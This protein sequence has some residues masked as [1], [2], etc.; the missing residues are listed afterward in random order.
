MSQVLDL[1]G[2]VI[3]GTYTL[4]DLGLD[5]VSWLGTTFL[6]AAW[7]HDDG[8]IDWQ[9]GPDFF[10]HLHLIMFVL[11]IIISPQRL[12]IIRR[13]FVIFAILNALRAFTVIV[14]SLPDA[15]PK[16]ALQ[17]DNPVTGAYKRQPM[18]PAN[19]WRGFKVL[20]GH[21]TCGDMIFSGHATL[22]LLTLKT[23]LEC[24]RPY[25]TEKRGCTLQNTT[26]VLEKC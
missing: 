3:E 21:T 11:L 26:K 22:M 4:P 25:F 14:T 6:P 18:F 13:L 23:Y 5:L 1:D 20:C 16:C 24:V 7:I 15:S 12:K 9:E 2:N 19:L 8:C 17:W 10:V